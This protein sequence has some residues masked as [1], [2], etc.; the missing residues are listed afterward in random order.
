M[1]WAVLAAT[2]LLAGCEFNRKTG[3][4]IGVANKEKSGVEYEVSVRNVIVGAFFFETL[5]VPV[6]VGLADYKCPVAK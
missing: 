4:C 1:K 6:Y 5:W 3:P 2:L